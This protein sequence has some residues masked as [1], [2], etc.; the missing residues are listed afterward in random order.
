MQLI[1]A[2]SLRKGG[3]KIED[4][5]KTIYLSQCLSPGN[6]TEH[7]NIQTFAKLSTQSNDP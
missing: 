7:R 1:Q 6:Y 5:C 2:I 4:G 3:Q